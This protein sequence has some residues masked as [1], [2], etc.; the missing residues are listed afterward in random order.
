VWSGSPLDPANRGCYLEAGTPYCLVGDD[1]HLAA[2]VIVPQEDVPFVH[3]EQKVELLL[4]GLGDRTVTG[5]VAEVSPVPVDALPREIAAAHLVPVD[6][7]AASP[8]RPLEPVYRVKV[9]LDPD[10]DPPPLLRWTTGDARIQLSSEPL[11]RRLWRAMQR[12]FHFDL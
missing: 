1:S 9:V 11:G 2:T 5:T 3:P 10:D 12:T 7:K 4:T 6:T 8:D